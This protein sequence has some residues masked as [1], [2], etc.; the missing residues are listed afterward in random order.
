MLGDGPRKPREAFIV[1][2]VGDIDRYAQ[3][4]RF[5]LGPDDWHRI[6]SRKARRAK[7]RARLVQYNGSLMAPAEGRLARNALN[8]AGGN[9]GNCLIAAGFCPG[10]QPIWN[11]PIRPLQ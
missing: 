7:D 3:G 11:E 4:Y 8:L 10:R 1:A 9:A 5:Q 2:H 6:S